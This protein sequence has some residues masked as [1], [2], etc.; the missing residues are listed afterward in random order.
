M[1]QVNESS[2]LTLRLLEEINNLID[3]LQFEF[4]KK[5]WFL[6][7]PVAQ[8][9]QLYSVPQESAVAQDLITKTGLSRDEANQ[10]VQMAQYLPAWSPKRSNHDGRVPTFYRQYL[11]SRYDFIG[12]TLDVVTSASLLASIFEALEKAN[13]NRN[14]RQS[15]ADLFFDEAVH[16]NQSSNRLTVRQKLVWT[17]ARSLLIHFPPD[18]LA[19]LIG[20]RLNDLIGDIA[21]QKR[22]DADDC[23]WLLAH[24]K[25]EV[26]EFVLK[27]IGHN[28][29]HS[30]DWI[31]AICRLLD[32]HHKA[33]SQ[34]PAQLQHGFALLW[35]LNRFSYEGFRNAAMQYP[36]LVKF[37]TQSIYEFAY[38]Y[39]P[40]RQFIIALMNYG[41]KFVAEGSEDRVEKDEVEAYF[42]VERVRRKPCQG[43]NFIIRGLELSDAGYVEKLYSEP[44]R[45]GEDL[46][47]MVG[48]MLSAKLK[49]DDDIEQLKSRLRLARETS[50]LTFLAVNLY[51]GKQACDVLQLP[52]AAAELCHL[53]RGIA[54]FCGN[55]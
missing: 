43:L 35:R 28:V 14:L 20:K 37:A 40:D 3:T 22:P 52:N 48:T 15:V 18:N 54:L 38:V 9:G 13:P 29:K 34:T 12:D 5:E 4:A 26:I 41:R 25:Q 19:D 51:Y 50:V 6:V 44:D 33:A 42:Q 10:L 24:L 8:N 2:K 27:Q 11:I 47:Q 1:K 49:D 7:R 55:E 39:N 17:I 46:A 53:V 21:K 32:S 36:A 23:F 45:Y 30:N 31:H 16:T